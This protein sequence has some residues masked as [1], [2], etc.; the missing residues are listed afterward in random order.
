MLKPIAILGAGAWGTALA[1]HLAHRGQTVRLWS[2]EKSEITDMQASGENNRFLPGFPFPSTLH[3]TDQLTDAIADVDLALI[4]I[5]SVA[6]R[7]TLVMLRETQTTSLNILSATKGLEATS[8]Q[9]LHQVVRDVMGE[10]TPFAV[11]SG[12]S[13][14]KE[15]AAGQPTSVMIASHFPALI[16]AI[17]TRFTTNTF[18]VF[19]TDDVAGVEVGAIVKNIVAIA[20]GIADGLQLG[21]NARSA[22]I[23]QG[24]HEMML[25]GSTLGARVDTLVGL[26]GAGD[27]ILTCTDNQSRNRRF[28]LALGAGKTESDA[29]KEIG[30]V[31]EGKSNL[32]L[33]LRLATKQGITL[34]IAQ[35]I[36]RLLSGQCNANDAI[37]HILSV[38]Q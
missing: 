33:A 11:L 10:T 26:A 27:L 32:D 18:R 1:I 3:A 21:A 15:V 22:I 16:N 17:Q 25:L 35:T 29:E 6:F 19:P 38:Q 8:G 31:V 34:T 7:K 4:A 12:P 2:M 36:S 20:V 24:L 23:T 13:F 37:N 5:P 9:L 28:G 14:A 30:H